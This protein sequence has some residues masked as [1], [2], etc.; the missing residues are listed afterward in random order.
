MK[1]TNDNVDDLKSQISNI[2]EKYETLKSE[3]KKSN[4]A[5]VM[6]LKSEIDSLIKELNPIQ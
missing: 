1:K 2:T 3:M 5:E 6:K 4:N